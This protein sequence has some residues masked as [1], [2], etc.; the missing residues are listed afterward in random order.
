MAA[1]Y[2]ADAGF[3]VTAQNVTGDRVNVYA[4]R[5]PVV[6]FCRTWTRCPRS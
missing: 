4:R 2:L 6:T 3:E 1:D 5:D